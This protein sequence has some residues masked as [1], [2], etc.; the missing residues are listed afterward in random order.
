MSQARVSR[1]CLAVFAACW[2]IVI[3]AAPYN[4]SQEMQ[5]I[6]PGGE[7]ALAPGPA[8]PLTA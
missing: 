5:R 1:A 2:G 6:L 8:A 3:L 4:F 7:K